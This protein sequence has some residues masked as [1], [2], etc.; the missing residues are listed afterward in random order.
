VDGH[1]C[2]L[3]FDTLNDDSYGNP[4]QTPSLHNV[5]KTGPWTWHGWQTD[6]GKSLE[7][8]MTETMFGNKP[9]AE[10]VKALIAYLETL[11]TPPN[12]H[13]GANGEFSAAA[14]RGQA[15]FHGKARCARCHKGELY[16]S[17]SNYDVKIESDGSPYDLWN[18]PSLLG[19]WDRGP[20]LHDGRA[21]TLDE[22]IRTHHSS[23]KLGG[24]KLTDEERRD[25]VEFL[26]SL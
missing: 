18:P 15:I 5:T 9:S 26:K 1:T 20:Y 14:Q 8:S 10:D 7:K 6:L 3:R 24:Q 19:L 25:L 16:T 11:T 4:K 13:R 12:P 21:A 22:T 17:E 2:G 23:E